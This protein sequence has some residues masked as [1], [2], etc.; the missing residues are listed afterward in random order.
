MVPILNYFSFVLAA[1]ATVQAEL[2]H[3]DL[4]ASDLDLQILD[5]NFVQVALSASADGF[6]IVEAQLL[7]GVTYYVGMLPSTAP[8]A[9]PYNLS[10]DVN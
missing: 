5:E 2:S 6:E 8:G 4:L 9:A 1:D 7:A 3:F 10:I